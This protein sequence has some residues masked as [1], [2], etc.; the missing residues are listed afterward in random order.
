MFGL[1]SYGW[2]VV[3]VCMWVAKGASDHLKAAII[4]R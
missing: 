1:V 2:V 3:L 4:A